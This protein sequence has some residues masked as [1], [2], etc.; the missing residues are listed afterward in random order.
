MQ[1]SQLIRS[2]TL[3]G[4]GKCRRRRLGLA[5]GTAVVLLL[6]WAQVAL[7]APPQTAITAMPPST[8]SFTSATFEFSSDSL[9]PSVTF[10]CRL[11]GGTSHPCDSPQTYGPPA[12][13]PFDQPLAEGQ[14][15]FSVEATDQNGTGLPATYDWTIDTTVPETTFSTNPPDLTGPSATFEFSSSEPGSSFACQLD[16]GSPEP[17]SSP[18]NYTGLTEGSHALSV[19]ATDPAGNTDPTP[20]T[21]MWAVDATAPQVTITG[22]SGTINSTSVTF[23]FVSDDPAATFECSLDSSE[24]QIC[25][26]PQ[27]YSGLTEGRHSFRVRATDAVGNSSVG[28]FD[29]TVSLPAPPA[30]ESP[31]I[32]DQS[33]V[34]AARPAASFVLIAGR[35]VKVNRNRAVSVRLN[36]SGTKECSGRV[37]LTTASGVRFHRHKLVLRLG[38]ARFSIPAAATAKVKVRLSKAK[39]RLLKR[40][41]RAKV[42][43]TVTDVDRAGRARISTREITL[44]A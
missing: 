12:P 33:S 5:F 17:C 41:K 2:A 18:H 16:S 30:A 3:A 7:A 29:F 8:T 23:E 38:S 43:V 37:V 6:A 25:T 28:T 32:T 42:L 39:Y 21:W 22:P 10:A 31:P 40:L 13:P 11:D 19:R 44:R 20:A 35:A 26:S 24:F 15:T 34:L 14:H 9:D 27:P 36:C 1:E 4:R